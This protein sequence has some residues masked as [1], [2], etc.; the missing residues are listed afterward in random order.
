L[1]NTAGA[2]WLG[3]RGVVFASIGFSSVSL[4]G[5]FVLSLHSKRVELRQGE[6]RA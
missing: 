3:L 4:I 1:L 5:M 6:E 2:F